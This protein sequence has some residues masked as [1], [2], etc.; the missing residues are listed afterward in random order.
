MSAMSAVRR[1]ARGTF[2]GW[3]VVAGAIGVQILQS[4]LMLQ[5]FG[6]YVPVWREEFGWS[7]TALATVFSIQRL[8]SGLLG[9]IAVARQF[10][11]DQPA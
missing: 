6:I 5:A 3:W 1:W 11:Q 7:K 2:Y 4:G 8:E 9:R 10:K